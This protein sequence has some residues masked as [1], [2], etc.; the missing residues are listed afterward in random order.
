M[1]KYKSIFRA[2]AILVSLSFNSQV[3]FSQN[4][5]FNRLSI[6]DGLLS[7][8]VLCSWQ[9]DKGYLWLGT[10][11]GLQRFDGYVFRTILLQ[12]IDQIIKDKKGRVWMRSGK[13]IGTFDPTR[14]IFS[15]SKIEGE[16]SELDPARLK[17]KT[18]RSGNVFLIVNGKN[19]QFFNEGSNQFGRAYN[20]FNIP[21]SIRIIEVVDD[22]LKNRYWIAAYNGLGYWDKKTRTYYNYNNNTQNDFLLSNEYF[23]GLVSGFFIDIKNRYWI[24]AWKG[25][26]WKAF[27]YDAKLGKYTDDTTGIANAGNGSYFDIY[28]YETLKDSTTIIYG[29]NCLRIWINGEFTELRSSLENPFAIQFNTVNTVFQDRDSIIWFSTDNGLYSTS[30]TIRQS[31]RLILSQERGNASINSLF[32]DDMNQIWIGTWGR[33][34]F[35]SNEGDRF[36]FAPLEKLYSQDGFTKLTWSISQHPITGEMWIGCQEGRLILYNNKT[37]SHRLFRPAIFRNSTIR[38][39]LAEHNGTMW[40]GLNNGDLIKYDEKSTI[41]KDTSFRKVQ[42]FDGFISKMKFD[43]RGNLWVSVNGKGIFVL[44]TQIEQT[45]KQYGDQKG[46]AEI[47]SSTRDILPMNDSIYL[48]AADKLG[49][50]NILNDSI[51]TISSLNNFLL[52]RTFSLQMDNNNNCWIATSN[53]IFKF[54]PINKNITRYTQRD[55]LITVFNSSYI[56]EVSLKLRNNKLI[57][58]GNRHLV[59]FDPGK[60]V[61]TQ[62]PPDV[63]ITGF[64]L[65]H[66]YLPEDSVNQLKKIRLPYNNNSF[67]IEFAALDYFQHD[68]ITYEY[69]L[70]GSNEGWVAMGKPGAIKYNL[71]PPGNY[72]FQVRSVNSEGLYS[73]NTTSL[74]IYIAP[75]FWKTIWFYLLI[76]VLVAAILFYLHRLKVER[77]LHIEKVR[78]RLARDLHDDMGSTLSTINILSNIALNQTPLDEKASKGYMTTINTSTT[79][80]MESMDDIV[81][82]I[83]PINDS[84]PKVLARMKE[85]AGN[86]L[87]PNNIDY[88]FET[89]PG[90]RNLNFSMEWR[91]EIFLIFK[92]ALNNII[93]YSKCTK[94]LF[95]LK[96]EGRSFVFMIEDNGLGFDL[97]ARSPATRGNGLKNMKKRAEMINASLQLESQPGKGTRLMLNIP[98]A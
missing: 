11:N 89:D 3:I 28:G 2:L 67:T 37:K 66:R 93:K 85:M 84:L 70:T 55:G 87:E 58:A 22:P 96:K 27:C 65:N 53:G 74:N 81:W 17:L 59:L 77:L 42:H 94:V 76:G 98:V 15:P 7:N 18:D 72:Q 20:P 79:T 49:L 25:S 64:Q 60:Y 39:I 8:N 21:D 1:A 48:L 54:N 30:G 40:I 56:P 71:L 43:S 26:A 29:L 45:V 36:V 44:D 32:Q 4:F 52:G 57:F 73:K 12:R 50:L 47:T 35:I 69:R 75:P 10:E 13:N 24:T 61:S 46:G 90:I 5:T 92:E 16:N 31:L 91:R 19:C 63:L 34:A 78:S 86:V 80:M 38:Q 6:Q 95:T 41:L 88:Q 62:S 83:N 51:E 14:H 23:K 97:D 82:S 9:D 33:G 68:K